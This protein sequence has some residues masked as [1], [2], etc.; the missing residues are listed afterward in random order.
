M[1]HEVPDE[2]IQKIQKLIA[3]KSSP[4]ENE[5]ALAARKVQELLE[6]Y[7]LEEAKVLGHQPPS[8]FSTFDFIYWYEEDW[9]REWEVRLCGVLA[10]AYFC[11]VLFSSQEITIIGRER[12]VDV[13]RQ[14]FYA[15]RPQLYEIGQKRRAVYERSLRDQGYHDLRELPKNERPLAF[16]K[17]WLEGTLRGVAYQVY[18]RKKEFEKEVSSTGVT[19]REL[20]VI[21]GK[22]LDDELDSRNVGRVEM[23]EIGQNMEGLWA[24]QQDGIKANLHRGALEEKEK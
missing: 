7:N 15:L 2:L 6:R 1:N 5:S 19:G 10:E 17:G 23:D 22:E 20:M 9:E 14:V 11:R 4:N 24:G 16:Y 8:K 21:R 18:T 3:L 13:A 12:E